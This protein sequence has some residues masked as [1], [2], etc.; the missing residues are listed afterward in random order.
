[1][2]KKGSVT[3]GIKLAAERWLDQL[4]TQFGPRCD[5]QGEGLGSPFLDARLH[6]MR[7]DGI[8]AQGS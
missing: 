2:I 6:A 4:L 5:H 1:V 8:D 7:S 3:N